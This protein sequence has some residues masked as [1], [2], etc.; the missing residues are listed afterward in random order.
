MQSTGTGTGE[1]SLI[2][3]PGTRLSNG[4]KS[5]ITVGFDTGG[6]RKHPV[7]THE[8]TQ[9][10]FEDQFYAPVGLNS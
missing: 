7:M 1:G 8:E 4:I 5:V 3:A 2:T 9:V 6:E 10:D